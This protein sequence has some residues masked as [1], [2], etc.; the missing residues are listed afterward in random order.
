MARTDSPTVPDDHILAVY[1]RA[2][3]AFERG[4]GVRLWST[5]GEAYLDCVAGIAVGVETGFV[6]V[7]VVVVGPH[8]GR[9][10]G[11]SCCGSACPLV[12]GTATVSATTAVAA[13]AILLM[14]APSGRD[15]RYAPTDFLMATRRAG[16][17]FRFGHL[18]GGRL[19]RQS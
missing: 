19:W 10:A 11:T 14:G 4:Q 9:A 18:G 2:P 16:G 12:S 6:S 13:S 7:S 3:L 5:D 1:N 17:A 8:G 15:G